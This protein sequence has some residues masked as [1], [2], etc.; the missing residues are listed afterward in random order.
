LYVSVR[1]ML[2]SSSL[3]SVDPKNYADQFSLRERSNERGHETTAANVKKRDWLQSHS[4]STP[5]SSDASDA[6]R[7]RYTRWMPGQSEMRAN[8]TK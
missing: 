7:V 6:R 5:W 1:S 4:I 3:D 2:S 8:N